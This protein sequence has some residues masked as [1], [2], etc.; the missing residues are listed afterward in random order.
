M[1]NGGK[2]Q[3]EMES[4]FRF[5]LQGGRTRRNNGRE[6]GNSF[7]TLSSSPNWGNYLLDYL[8]RTEQFY[9]DKEADDHKNRK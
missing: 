3:R 9:P 7:R 1:E 8:I 4:C 5:V 2:K 6:H